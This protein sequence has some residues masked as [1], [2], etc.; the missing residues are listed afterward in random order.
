MVPVLVLA[1]LLFGILKERAAR[2]VSGFSTLPKEEQEMYDRA[3]ISRD[4]RNSCFI[5][6]GTMLAGAALSYFVTPYLAIL[7]YIVWGVLFFKD[8]HFDEHKAFEKY[9]EKIVICA[10]WIKLICGRN[11]GD[12]ISRAPCLF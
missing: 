8:V 3:Y 12:G 10:L 6:S 9:L 2:F 7:A 1:G 11:M 4:M 5:W